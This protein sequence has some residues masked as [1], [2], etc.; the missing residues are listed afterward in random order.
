MLSQARC[1][2]KVKLGPLEQALV[3][4]SPWEVEAKA[5][6]LGRLALEETA[7]LDLLGPEG[8]H[9]ISLVSLVTGVTHNGGDNVLVSSVS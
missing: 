1:L 5:G 7:S 9:H 2:G 6:F 4:V 3:E 8:H